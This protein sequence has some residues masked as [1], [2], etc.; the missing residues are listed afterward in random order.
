[1]SAHIPSW[2]PVLAG[3]VYCFLLN[4]IQAGEVRVKH[5]DGH[6]EIYVDDQI[7]KTQ[8]L[9]RILG[10]TRGIKPSSL[11][12]KIQFKV[13]SAEL[14]S[15][16]KEQLQP[17]GEALQSAELQSRS[18]IIEGHTDRSG[19]LSRNMVLS[20]KRAESVRQYLT[21]NFTIE[22]SQLAAAGLGPNQPL[23]HA[24]PFNP[25]NR[26]VTFTAAQ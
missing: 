3:L 14:T 6:E 12:L 8:D 20:K 10:S 5:G 9:V 19:Q 22:S 4:P 15:A 24:D 16:A 25:I 1:M 21:Q 17:L 13:G 23:D 18:Y 7:P 11:A 2:C 26:R